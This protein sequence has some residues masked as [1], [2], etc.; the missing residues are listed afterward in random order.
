MGDINTNIRIDELASAARGLAHVVDS[1]AGSLLEIPSFYKM[2]DHTHGDTIEQSEFDEIVAAIGRG[3]IIRTGKLTRTGGQGYLYSENSLI[4]SSRIDYDG[5]TP[6]I[7]HLFTTCSILDGVTASS[8][9]EMLCDIK[10]EHRTNTVIQ[11]F[12]M[13]Q[14]PVVQ[15]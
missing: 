10:L 2:K 1:L 7:I 14:Y 15:S 5:T 13:T 8:R 9:T 12:L 3:D 11:I 6:D 4:I